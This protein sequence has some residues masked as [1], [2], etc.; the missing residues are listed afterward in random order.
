L[1]RTLGINMERMRAD[2]G[3]AVPPAEHTG[4][5]H[6]Y[7]E[8]RPQNRGNRFG[9]RRD[10]GGRHESNRDSRRYVMV[11]AESVTA[12]SQ[13]VRLPGEVFQIEAD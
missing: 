10:F 12:R 8:Q 9:G 3:G 1:E 11:G 7:H 2:D 5:L 4:K 13:M 6:E